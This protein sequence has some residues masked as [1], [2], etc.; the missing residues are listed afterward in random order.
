[1][2]RNS[3]AELRFVRSSFYGGPPPTNGRT[4]SMSQTRIT[5]IQL[6]NVGATSNLK[7]SQYSTWLQQNE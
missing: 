5:I 3:I 2:Y 6:K 1:M 7:E 4:G